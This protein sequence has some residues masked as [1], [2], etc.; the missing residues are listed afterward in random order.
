MSFLKKQSLLIFMI[1][2]M[3]WALHAQSLPDQGQIGIRAD[4]TGQPSV[5]IPY[6]LNDN[7][8]L[9]PYFSLNSLQDQFTD[10][11]IGIR[12]RYYM[13]IRSALGSYVTGILGLSNESNKVTDTSVTD[14]ILGAG[15]GGEYLFSDHFSVS[16]DVNLYANFGDNPNSFGTMARV[17][18]TVYF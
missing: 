3:S 14:F 1:F 4:L 9:A 18:A 8:S 16:A 17:S 7:L 11:G 15:Y 2:G 13:G 6:M 10:F 12:P 5:E